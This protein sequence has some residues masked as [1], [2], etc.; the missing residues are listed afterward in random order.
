MA[1]YEP[2]LSMSGALYAIEVL[3][4]I[5]HASRGGYFCI[6]FFETIS[7]EVIFH[8][9]KYQLRRLKEHYEF[10]I[11]SNVIA[12]VNIT[13]SIAESIIADKKI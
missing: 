10:L 7:D 6:C 13:Y 1:Y 4:R 12:S 11:S 3:S 9:F 8:I 2:I 5:T